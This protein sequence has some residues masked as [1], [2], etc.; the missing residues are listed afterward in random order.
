MTKNHDRMAK[1]YYKIL[2]VDKNASAEDI[3]KA[4]RKLAHQYHP[5]KKGGDE[6]RFKEVNEAYQVLGDPE[7][8]KRYDQFGS[9]FEQQGGFGGGMSWDDF[10]RAA[11]G[12]GGFDF[13]NFSAKGG[14]AF[15]GDFGNVDLGDLFGDMFGFGGRGGRGRQRVRRGNDVQVDIEIS[16]HE[17]AFGVE[18]E[19]RLIK[20][21]ACDVCGGSGME[22]GSKMHQCETCHGQGQIAQMQR[23]FLG[24]VQT[25][26]TC[27][28]CGGVGQVPE[29]K[30]KHCGGRGTM[31]SES[32][33]RVKIPA[34]IDEGESI[35]LD[36]RG[37]SGGAGGV[38]GDLYVRVH[39]LAD[40]ALTRDGADVHSEITISY[41]QAVLGDTVEIATLDGKKKIVI[42][43]GTQSGQQIR[44]RGLGVHDLRGSGRGD[45][46]VHVTV[47]VPKKVSRT[48]RKLLEDLKGEI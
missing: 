47:D 19:I 31:K 28:T 10:M 4:F 16:F 24:A 20:N 46:Y 21:N 15:G 44:L 38:A 27:T 9:D 41:P 17:A 7:K 39:V 5:D 13:G 8:R 18:K 12:Q 22:P 6:E 43:E 30:C 37:E 2:G 1:D 32:T 33:Y 36:G 25:V 26:T 45:H 34:G 11:R 40:P 42:P 14:S 48:A 23:T 29:K 35:R 3:K